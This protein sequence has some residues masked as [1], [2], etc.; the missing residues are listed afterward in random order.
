MIMIWYQLHHLSCPNDIVSDTSESLE[1]IPKIV[2]MSETESELEQD[3]EKLLNI[4]K[5]SVE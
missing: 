5:K 2:N 3:T 1:I 4:L